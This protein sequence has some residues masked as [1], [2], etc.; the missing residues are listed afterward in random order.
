MA[1]APAGPDDMSIGIIGLSPTRVLA[2]Q[3]TRR[4]S[5]IRNYVS[6]TRVRACQPPVG[7]SLVSALGVSA[8]SL[9]TFK[10]A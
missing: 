9:H 7:S 4:P 10:S 5:S 2:L 1:G 3:L 6:D 8:R